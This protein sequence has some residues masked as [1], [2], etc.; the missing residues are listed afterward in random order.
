MTKTKAPPPKPPPKPSPKPLNKAATN[1][2][3]V[4]DTLIA[5]RNLGSQGAA[6]SAPPQIPL[7][8]KPASV[9]VP[10]GLVP[11]RKLPPATISAVP[12]NATNQQ[13]RPEVESG[14]APVPNESFPGSGP[15]PTQNPP[16]FTQPVKRPKQPPSI[17]IPK[18]VRFKVTVSSSVHSNARIR[19]VLPTATVLG[20]R[21]TKSARNAS[22]FRVLIPPSTAFLLY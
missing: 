15:K 22:H 20:G 17:F 10:S 2:H 5:A 14:R 18:K 1:V 4:P 11:A 9:P 19:S 13:P 16:R 8:E 6:P 21:R 3:V 7:P 12:M